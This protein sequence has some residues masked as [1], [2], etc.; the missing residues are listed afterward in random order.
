MGSEGDNVYC[1]QQWYSMMGRQFI[2]T[3]ACKTRTQYP[4][5]ARPRP[6]APSSGCAWLAGCSREETQPNVRFRS[7]FLPTDLTG[8]QV[9]RTNYLPRPPRP[10]QLLSRSK[11][12]SSKTLFP[13][14][15]RQF[16]NS[17][18]LQQPTFNRSFHASTANMTIKCYFD[19]SW[20]GPLLAVTN[21]DG[22][23]DQSKS[24]TAITGTSPMPNAISINAL[25]SSLPA[26]IPMSMPLAPCNAWLASFCSST[27]TDRFVSHRAHRPHQLRAIR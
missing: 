2:I 16:N 3:T 25:S 26:S 23:I 27:P 15:L 14:T 11:M 13:S 22:K 24:D 1:T 10:R 4:P 9:A 21:D 19:I 20:K 18:R 17:I 12:F 7:T 5:L 8:Q 6:P